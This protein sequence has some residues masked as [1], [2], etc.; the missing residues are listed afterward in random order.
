VDRRQVPRFAARAI[1]FTGWVLRNLGAS[2][3]SLDQHHAALE[4]AAHGQVIVELAI[5]ARQD[6]AEHCLDHGDLAG[7]ESQLAA[8]AALH[9]GD[10]VFGW[11]LDLKHRLIRGRLAL[12]AGD[13]GQAL[14]IATGLEARAAGL[15]VP[16]Y[17]SVARLLRHRASRALGRPVDLDLVAADLD[18]LDASV[19]IE[20]WWWTGDVAADFA[21]PRWLDRAAERAGRLARRAGRYGDGLRLAAGRR[22]QD[23][24]AIARSGPAA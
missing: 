17:V 24:Q 7:A 11:R 23:W 12:R 4:Q 5:A 6:L 21:V 1:N 22:Q 16:R 20:A 8:A 9:Q 19:A 10:L 2:Q 13:P 3:E 15:G 18:L 14:A